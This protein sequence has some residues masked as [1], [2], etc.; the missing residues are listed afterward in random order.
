MTSC[1]RTRRVCDDSRQCSPLV[2]GGG[3]GGR[4][5]HHPRRALPSQELRPAGSWAASGLVRPS[6]SR[7]VGH[8]AGQ[9]S[10]HRN[11]SCGPRND[12][13]DGWGRVVRADRVV[14]TRHGIL[15]VRLAI[16]RPG[17]P[18]RSTR[19]PRPSAGSVLGPD[20]GAP[21]GPDRFS[22]PGAAQCPG[23]FDWRSSLE[24]VSIPRLVI[25]GDRDN[26]PV[27]GAREWVAGRPN[28]RLLVL[29]GVGH[30]PQYERPRETLN[31][32]EGFL[33]G[34]WPAGSRSIPR[35]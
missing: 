2:P 25:H 14:G 3:A 10:V 27:E 24:R 32:I 6:A 20:E 1:P 33:S 12:S 11:R 15:L 30:W 4:D 17:H 13:E 19:V 35:A 9:Q 16:P 34:H 28:A 23:D 29:R 26:F 18:T 8:R 31:A 22:G 21:A 5:G 7:A